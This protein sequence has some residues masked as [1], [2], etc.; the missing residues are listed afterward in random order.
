LSR[1]PHDVES[2]ETTQMIMYLVRK[3]I[4]P[5][6]LLDCIH[7][8]RSRCKRRIMGFRLFLSLFENTQSALIHQDFAWLLATSIRECTFDRIE[9][10]SLLEDDLE[11]NKEEDLNNDAAIQFGPDEADL[12]ENE[13]EEE[14][15]EF[16]EEE[17]EKRRQ[18]RKEKREKRI[19]EFKE[20]KK[21][22]ASYK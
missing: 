10:E 7:S 17:A 18:R 3:N 8:R 4:S 1:V 5:Q 9:D 21:K 13:I 11:D 6:V 2:N 14:I 20:R 22:N 19:Q 15:N 16:G 12:N